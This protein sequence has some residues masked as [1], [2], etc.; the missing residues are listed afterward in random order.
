[1]FSYRKEITECF[2]DE[3]DKYQINT[4]YRHV[5]ESNEEIS[6]KIVIKGYYEKVNGISKQ[7]QERLIN[8][9]I[10][11]ELLSRLT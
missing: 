2:L 7:L 6:G 5:V 8:K 11:N 9:N 4:L 3:N 10:T 1:M